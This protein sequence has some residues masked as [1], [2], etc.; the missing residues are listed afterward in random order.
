MLSYPK[1]QNKK[2]QQMW[3]MSVLSATVLIFTFELTCLSK[4][5]LLLSQL[6]IVLLIISVYIYSVNVENYVGS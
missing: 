2:E 1:K 3:Y 6:A 4:H 5:G